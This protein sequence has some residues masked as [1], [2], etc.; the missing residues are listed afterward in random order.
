MSKLMKNDSNFPIDIV[1]PWVDGND[2]N[3][4]K[5]KSIYANTKSFDKSNARYRDWDNLQ[6]IFRGIDKFLP[7]I[8]K[9]FFI[10][11]GQKPEWL[12]LNHPKLKFVTHKDY[13]PSEYIPT[14][15]S[16]PIEVNLHRIKDLSEHFIYINDDMFFLKFQ[17]RKDYFDEEGKPCDYTYQHS[18]FNIKGDNGFGINIIDFC[19]LGIINAHFRKRNVIKGHFLKW[20]GPYLGFKGQFLALL[21]ARQKFFLGFDNSH[22]PQSFKKS[23]YSE[24]WQEEYEYLHKTSLCKFREDTNVS[25]YLFRYWQLAKNDFHPR[26]F[27]DRIMFNINDNNLSVAIDAITNGKYSDICINDSEFSKISNFEQTKTLINQALNR[28]LPDKCTFEL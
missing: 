13:L 25:Q 3:W 15:S 12:N 9:V 5:E 27:K 28:V 20:Y 6:Y 18:L 10:T 1:L 14:F 23:T 17:R 11:N 24:V 8:N 19:C 26:S 7:W 16:H 2:R 21:K 22:T 4:Q